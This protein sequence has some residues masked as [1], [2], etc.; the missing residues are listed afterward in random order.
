MTVLLFQRGVFGGGPGP[1]E[2]DRA[3]VCGE[4][5]PQK[6]FKRKREQHRER[7]RRPEEVSAVAHTHIYPHPSTHTKH[8]HIILLIP[9]YR[10]NRASPLLGS[11]PPPSVNP[12][13]PQVTICSPPTTHSDKHITTAT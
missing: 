7:D 4:V 2:A 12:L 1:G 13:R 8:R 9:C 11:S 3:D 6:G 10:G 5:H